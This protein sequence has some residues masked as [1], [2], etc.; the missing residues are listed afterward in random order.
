MPS[1]HPENY[2]T[3]TDVTRVLAQSVEN[4]F[5]PPFHSPEV[6]DGPQRCQMFR[7]PVFWTMCWGRRTL[8]SWF[9]ML[10]NTWTRWS[11]VTCSTFEMK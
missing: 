4:S 10:S 2:T 9:I 6:I 8:T 11:S 3:L 5:Y 7:Y 1:G